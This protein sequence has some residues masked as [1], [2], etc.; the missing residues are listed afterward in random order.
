MNKSALD[1]QMSACL[2]FDFFVGYCIHLTSLFID[3]SKGLAYN[4]VT[5]LLLNLNASEGILSFIINSI[6]LHLTIREVYESMFTNKVWIVA[7]HDDLHY[8]NLFLLITQL[9]M[10]SFDGLTEHYQLICYLCNLLNSTMKYEG[11][12]W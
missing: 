3:L 1:R 9:I 5:W 10:Y 12:L 6:E 7:N 4:S 2:T 11:R 8:T